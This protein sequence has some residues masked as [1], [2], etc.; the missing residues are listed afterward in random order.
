MIFLVFLGACLEASKAVDM[1][2]LFTD[3]SS[4][5]IVIVI[6]ITYSY[7]RQSYYFT[8]LGKGAVYGGSYVF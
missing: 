6:A 4:I 3:L 2:L 8:E 5:I 7:S 1:P